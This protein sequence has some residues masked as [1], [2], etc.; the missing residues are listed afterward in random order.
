MLPKPGP[1]TPRDLRFL[2]GGELGRTAR[3]PK[4]MLHKNFRLPPP[5]RQRLA[6]QNIAIREERIARLEG[7]AGVLERLVFVDG[8]VL[9]RRALFFSIG[10]RQHSQLAAKLGCRLTAEG[11]VQV[12]WYQ[13]TNVA[14]LYVAGDA[15]SRVQLAIVAAAEGAKAA[16]AINFALLNE[17]LK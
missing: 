8:Q 12:E 14:R 7:T 10:H 15:S 5:A 13:A 3:A 2:R 1:G 16:F 6:A 9:P 17:D 4:S 11:T